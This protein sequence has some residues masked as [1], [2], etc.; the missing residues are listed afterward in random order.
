MMKT[1]KLIL[2]SSVCVIPLA[3]CEQK[4][5]EPEAVEA[6]DAGD[7]GTTVID[8]PQ[9][10][11]SFSGAPLYR[12]EIAP[13][14]LAEISQKARSLE[15]KET[16]SEDEY[17]ALGRHYIEAGRFRDTL[18]LYTKGLEAHPQSIK[19]RRHRAHRYIS[20]RE[21]DKA[22]VDLEEAVE[23]LGENPAPVFQIG[24]DGKPHGTYEHWVWYHIGLYHY[25]N[26]NYGEAAAAYEKCVDTASKNDLLIGATDWLYNSLMKNGEIEKAAAAIAAISPDI[27]ANED[28]PYYKRVMLFKGLVQPEELVDLDK[29]GAEWTG[30]EITIGYGVANWLKTQGDTDTAQKIYD[31]ILLSPRWSAW[32]YVVTDKEQSASKD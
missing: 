4:S 16:L 21:L 9:E 23:L 19:L 17:Y 28:H 11:T 3:A 25:L 22:I 31:K 14:R 27:N 15:E 12:Y 26:G 7:E 18:A 2:A 5:V 24:S 6:T 30:R 8:R 20:V 1:L 32:A 29:P 10:A 13:E